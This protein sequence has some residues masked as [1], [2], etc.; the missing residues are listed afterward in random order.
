VNHAD[1]V[2]LQALPGIGPR[3][4]QRIVAF[5]DQN[6]F[7]SDAQELLDI[8]GLSESVLREIEPYIVFGG[9]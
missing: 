9:R 6:G 2:Q 4:A 5:R 7:F 3:L 8:N 1:A